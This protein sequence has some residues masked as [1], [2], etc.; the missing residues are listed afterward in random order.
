MVIFLGGMAIIIVRQIYEIARE[1]PWHLSL[2]IYQYKIKGWQLWMLYLVLALGVFL[3]AAYFKIEMIWSASILVNLGCGLCL[4]LNWMLQFYHHRNDFDFLSNFMIHLSSFFK[5]TGKVSASLDLTEH[6][7]ASH[8]HADIT[9][10]REALAQNE[11]S[12]N[13][14][15]A[16]SKHYLLRSMISVMQQ[17]EAYGNKDV[18]LILNGLDRDIDTWIEQTRRDAVLR[19]KAK[20]KIIILCVL[21]VGV[22]MIS[23]KLLVGVVDITHQQAYQGTMTLFLH[24]ICFSIIWSHRILSKPWILKTELFNDI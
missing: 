22:A 3:V 4:V 9:E 12:L 8:P 15:S 1:K 19:L 20:N 23:Q 17:A 7:M 18:N 10:I 5:V 21:S 16:L 14:F 2:Q 11:D 6:I 13:A 24:C